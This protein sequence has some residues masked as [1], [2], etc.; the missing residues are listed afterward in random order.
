MI[1]RG[2]VLCVSS[3]YPHVCECVDFDC[4]C[5]CGVMLFSVVKPNGRATADPTKQQNNSEYLRAK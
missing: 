5:I 4:I 1:I 2:Y 3:A